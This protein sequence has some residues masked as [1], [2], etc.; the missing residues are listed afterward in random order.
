MNAR[1]QLLFQLP[2]YS[3]CRKPKSQSAAQQYFRFELRYV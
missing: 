3:D 2:A 1:T